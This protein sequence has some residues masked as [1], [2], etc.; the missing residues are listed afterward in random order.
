[1][2]KAQD[3]P[4]AGS[5]RPFNEYDDLPPAY[6]APSASTSKP[7]VPNGRPA[8]HYHVPGPSYAHPGHTQ[9]YPPN[10][11]LNTWQRPAPFPYPAGYFCQ[12]CQNTGIK[13]YNGHPCGTC[14]RLFGVQTAQ[15]QHLPAHAG[16][17]MGAPVFTAGDPR[18]GGRLCGNCKGYGT[19]QTLLG[20]VEE[21]CRVCRG[22]GRVF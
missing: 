1:M 7:Q 19:K 14:E 22:V 4:G 2:G 11:G 10:G 18:I 15:V 12:H 16:V 3:T 6:D 8:Q 17:P 5:S 20:L 13:H 21:Q 9:G